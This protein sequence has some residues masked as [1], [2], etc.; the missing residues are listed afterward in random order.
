MSAAELMVG[1]A[2][3]G[4][5]PDS[6]VRYGMRRLVRQRLTELAPGDCE[7]AAEMLETFLAAMAA[8]PVAPVPELAND[9]HYEL[10]PELLAAA[11]GPRRKYSCCYWPA[12]VATLAA[13]EEAALAATAERAELADGQRILE[14]GCGWGS[15]TLWTA[16]RYPQAAIVAVTNSAAQRDYVTAAAAERSLTNV[17]VV[18]AD[19]NAFASAQRF[20]RIVSVEMLEH[21]RNWEALFA[22][23]AS[24]L[25]PNG[26]FFMHVFCHRATPYEF[27]DAGPTD[28][29]G[30]HFF[31]GG[32]MPSDDLPLRFQRELALERRWRWSGSHYRRTAEAWLQNFDANAEAVRPILAATYGSANAELWRARWRMFFMAC[33]ELFGFADGQEWFVSHYRFVRRSAA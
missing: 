30:R 1:W 32:M 33:A 15:L 9:Q 17:R 6:A 27:V 22:R 16:E 29:M 21:M 8:A 13:A 7:Q 31:S 10:P 11:L 25:E 12:G 24:W 2:E 3:S 5:A 26:K 4:A 19:M 23:I 18:L 20:D 28:W 14:L